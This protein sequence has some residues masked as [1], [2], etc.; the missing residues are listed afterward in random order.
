MVRGLTDTRAHAP[1]VLA[2]RGDLGCARV[3]VRVRVRVRMRVRVT[4]TMKARVR[5]KY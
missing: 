1:H 4:V 3:R 2:A 5:K